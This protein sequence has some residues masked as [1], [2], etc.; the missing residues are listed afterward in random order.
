MPWDY[1]NRWKPSRGVSGVQGQSHISSP[2]DGGELLQRQGLDKARWGE[3]PVQGTFNCSGH[4]NISSCLQSP[5]DTDH[6]SAE[7]R[8]SWDHQ[9]ECRM[10][11]SL[12]WVTECASVHRLDFLPLHLCCPLEVV[13][14]DPWWFETTVLWLPGRSQL[15]ITQPSPIRNS[16][17]V[18]PEASIPQPGPRTCLSSAPRQSPLPLAWLIFT[19]L[20]SI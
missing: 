4:R 10:V 18:Q 6:F 5:P 13:N 9:D 16:S 19:D 15:R 12:Q 2:P 8:G 17:P 3:V 14:L 20:K 1:L 7:T 11:P